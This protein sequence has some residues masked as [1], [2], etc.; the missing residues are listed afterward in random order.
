MMSSQRQIQ[1][2]RDQLAA[3]Q[4]AP[5]FRTRRA[6]SI[7]LFNTP[8]TEAVREKLDDPANGPADLVEDFTNALQALE[9]TA[10]S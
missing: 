6:L 7:A 9:A 3:W 5:S 10:S 8:G 1:I 2:V 4:A